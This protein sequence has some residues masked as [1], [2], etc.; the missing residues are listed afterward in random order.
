MKR[1]VQTLHAVSARFDAQKLP[2]DKNY[3]REL[4]SEE[5]AE[6]VQSRLENDQEIKNKYQV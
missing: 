4:S 2:G 6:S 1:P 5:N 3:N